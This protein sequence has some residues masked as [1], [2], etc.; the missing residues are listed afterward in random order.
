[1]QA[2]ILQFAFLQKELFYPLFQY[3]EKML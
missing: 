2:F 3:I 1:M